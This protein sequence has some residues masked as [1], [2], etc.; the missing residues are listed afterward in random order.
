[1]GHVLVVQCGGGFVASVNWFVCFTHGSAAGSGVNAEAAMVDYG[2]ENWRV[3]RFY[4][5]VI[6]RLLECAAQWWPNGLLQVV[7]GGG[8]Q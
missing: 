1:L 4:V 2:D 8:C 3:R 6:V 5:C 7:D